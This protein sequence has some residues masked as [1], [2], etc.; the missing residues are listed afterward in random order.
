MFARGSRRRRSGH[1]PAASEAPDLG[2]PCQSCGDQ[3]PGFLVHGWRKICRHCKC[4]REEHTES[5]VPEDL[6][7]LMARLTSDFQRHS[8]SDDG[9][10]W[11]SEEYTWVPPGLRPEQVDRFFS[12]L[13][14]DKVPYVNSLG[15]RYR[16]QQ[17]LR[18]LPPHDSEAQYCAALE[19]EE[20]K[21]LRLFSQKRR[22]ENLGRGTV[23]AFPVSITGAICEQAGKIYCG[24]HHAERLRPRC[25]ACDEIIFAAECTEAEGQ[26]WHIQHFCCFEC[27]GPLGGQR[28]VMRGSRPHCGTCYEA[29]HTQ[30][31]DSC[32]E[33]IGMEQGQM[34]YGG[35]HWHA[36]ESCFSCCRCRRPLLGEPFLPRQ[37]QIFCS[38]VC[39][40]PIQA[41][42][43][44]TVAP[45]GAGATAICPPVPT[46][47][48]LQ[49][50]TQSGSLASRECSHLC[51]GTSQRHSMP[52]LG[53]RR[54]VGP[55]PWQ[56][57]QPDLQFTSAPNSAASSGGPEF[58]RQGE[59]RV[60]FQEPLL[61][62]VPQERKQLQGP[63]LLSPH[64]PP[65][66]ASHHPLEWDSIW[67]S[68]S[69]LSSSSDSEED[70]YFLGERIPLPPALQRAT[71]GP[72]GKEGKWRTCPGP[73]RQA[74]SQGQPQDRDR[75]CIVA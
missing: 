70:G 13:P 36:S 14:E 45:V 24:R 71:L 39:S 65:A 5:S 62:Q 37:G 9:S 17:L 63:A 20:E 55:S 72:Q 64:S 49:T 48:T 18:Q 56:P 40:L 32:G 27:E 51:R 30:Y 59:L 8:T 15:E 68:S 58:C 52:V 31:C 29:R 47:T 10:G 16:I 34:A 1:G 38:L 54:R 53:L 74:Q 6:E 69:S 43:A 60:N 50:R 42:A 61:A 46:T 22:R 28:Y 12:C 73:P 2:R 66:Q 35:Q 44:V 75:N 33:R 67:V 41:E 11:A 21:E 26:H 25:Q 23:R 3:C 19:E 57:L 4:P 7:Q